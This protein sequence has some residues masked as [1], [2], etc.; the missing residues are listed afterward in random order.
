MARNNIIAN[1]TGIYLQFNGNSVTI[2]EI[3]TKCLLWQLE[4][5][6]KI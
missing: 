4:D 2:V 3:H 5:D 6:G 1:H